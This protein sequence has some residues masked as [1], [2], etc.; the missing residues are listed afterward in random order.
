MVLFFFF[1]K[2]KAEAQWSAGNCLEG[3]DHHLH[4]FCTVLANTICLPD[5]S[6]C[7]GSTTLGLY[8][9]AVGLWRLKH[10][11]LKHHRTSTRVS[12][13]RMILAKKAVPGFRK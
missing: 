2:K 7:A 1:K 5:I 10:K 12:G 9:H 13:K 4:K 11:E 6:T 8:I 3:R